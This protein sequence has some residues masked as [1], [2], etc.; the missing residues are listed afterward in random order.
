[1]VKRKTRSLINLVLFVITRAFFVECSF[2]KIRCVFSQSTT[3]LKKCHTCL[4]D[5]AGATRLIL[6][7]KT[8]T[9][10]VSSQEVSVTYLTQGPSYFYFNLEIYCSGRHKCGA[11]TIGSIE[12]QGKADE[13]TEEGSEPSQDR[14]YQCLIRSHTLSCVKTLKEMS[15]SEIVGDFL[16]SENVN[17]ESFHL[18]LLFTSKTLEEITGS[19]RLGYACGG[20]TITLTSKTC[21][22]IV[23]TISG[24]KQYQFL[25][26]LSPFYRAD[27]EY[28]Q[29]H[30]TRPNER[31]TNK[32]DNRAQYFDT[33]LAMK[34]FCFRTTKVA[35]SKKSCVV[36]VSTFTKRIILAMG[37][38]VEGPTEVES[39]KPF[40]NY[41][42]SDSKPEF[43]FGKECD[44]TCG[45]V[46][47][48]EN[49]NECSSN[50]H[51]RFFPLAQYVPDATRLKNQ[52]SK[53]SS[54]NQQPGLCFWVFFIMPGYCLE[55]LRQIPLFEDSLTKLSRTTALLRT[56]DVGVLKC[57][58]P[59][60]SCQYIRDVPLSIC[61][62]AEELKTPQATPSSVKHTFLFDLNMPLPSNLY[63]DSTS[64]SKQQD[65]R[66]VTSDLTVMTSFQ[67]FASIT[68][69]IHFDKEENNM[70]LKL[71]RCLECLVVFEEVLLISVEHAYIWLTKKENGLKQLDDCTE[72]C[73]NPVKPDSRPSY[74][75]KDFQLLQPLSM[76][77]LLSIFCGIIL[78]N[79]EGGGPTTF[80]SVRG[81]RRS[82]D[83]T[84]QDYS[85]CVHYLENLSSI[86]AATQ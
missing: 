13:G 19:Y 73:S 32:W 77:D 80:E 66:S 52:L 5:K 26:N 27:P 82:R 68:T 22:S 11:I 54:S 58:R 39:E 67:S 71:F 9:E 8:K 33:S 17:G 75:F 3:T 7:E 59:H 30:E 31:N 72:E 81:K 49:E 15:G 56:G 74:P 35:D 37:R 79:E 46:A 20:V 34:P 42:F 4:L 23:K 1:M 65:A 62:Y 48:A 29:R 12:S 64:T 40:L 50:L 24:S 41:I 70:K 55:C 38:A 6:N 44:S 51:Q 78:P 60:S 36:C 45:N 10:T 28:R 21:G 2:G 43:K 57:V 83:V 69:V 16:L 47:Y 76:D 61:T 53:A 85:H 63:M 86:T 18:Y 84:Y 25:R 14:S